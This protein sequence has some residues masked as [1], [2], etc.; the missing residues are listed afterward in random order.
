MKRPATL[1]TLVALFLFDTT[2]AF[3]TPSTATHL[4]GHQNHKMSPLTNMQS[5]I[6]AISE[7][8]GKFIP[9]L[10]SLPNG[11]VEKAVSSNPGDLVLIAILGLLPR[12]LNEYGGDIIPAKYRSFPRHLQKAAQMGGAIYLINVFDA[13]IAQIFRQFSLA[14]NVKPLLFGILWWLPS[15]LWLAR[16]FKEGLEWVSDGV[17]QRRLV[18]RF[19][20]VALYLACFVLVTE[21][22]HMPV[23]Q[24]M[25]TILPLFVLLQLKVD[26]L[27]A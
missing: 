27:T 15:R 22:L 25:Q 1:L 21:G 14:N 6:P 10:P 20:A 5:S 9:F 7:Q 23:S 4:F 13:V 12:V 16:S 19:M 2:E 8:V 26:R 3:I 17:N 18:S 11:S 24:A